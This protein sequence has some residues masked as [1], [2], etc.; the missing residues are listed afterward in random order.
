MLR[1]C[2]DALALGGGGASKQSFRAE[3]F[4]DVGPVNPVA[5]A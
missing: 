3:V 5:S 1:L 2:F 4:V